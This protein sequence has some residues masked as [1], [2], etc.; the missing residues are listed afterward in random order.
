MPSSVADGSGCASCDISHRL[1]SQAEATLGT[2]QPSCVVHASKPVCLLDINIRPWLQPEGRDQ[3][4]E[5]GP[6]AP[7]TYGQPH[8]PQTI[9]KRVMEPKQGSSIKRWYVGIASPENSPWC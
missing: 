3:R 4:P 2:H 8:H 1:N 5:G 7:S 9:P 6:P